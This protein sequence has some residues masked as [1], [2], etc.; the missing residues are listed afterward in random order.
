M[1]KRLV[2]KTG[3][4]K[5]VL[6]G[7]Q[8]DFLKIFVKMAMQNQTR[9]DLFRAASKKKFESVQKIEPAQ[10]KT[11]IRNNPSLR[12]PIQ[13]D[14]RIVSQAAPVIEILPARQGG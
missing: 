2:T 12:V 6:L 1:T 14:H 3:N 8:R 7:S 5:R 10:L 13:S 11:P 4:K 9:N